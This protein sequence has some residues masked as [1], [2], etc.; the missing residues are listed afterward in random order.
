MADNGDHTLVAQL[1][2]QTEKSTLDQTKQATTAVQTGVKGIGTEADNT[3][4]KLL[5]LRSVTRE[6]GN[7]SMMTA[8]AGAAILATHDSGIE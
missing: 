4:Q 2:F 1:R 5:E 3:R 6:S 7:V 8:M